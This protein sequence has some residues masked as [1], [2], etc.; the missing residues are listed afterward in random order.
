LLRRLRVQARRDGQGRQQRMSGS[1]GLTW[2][3]RC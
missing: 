2:R 3:L 1:H